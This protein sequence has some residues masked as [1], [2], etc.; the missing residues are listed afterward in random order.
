MKRC[1][2]CGIEKSLDEYHNIR[3]GNS[4][5]KK[6][7]C[8]CCVNAYNR[9]RDRANRV[10]ETIRKQKWREK[11]RKLNR[12]TQNEYMKRLWREDPVFKLVESA[13]VRL[14][15]TCKKKGVIRTK[16]ASDLFGCTGNE[17]REHIESLFKEGMCWDNHGEWHLDHIRPISSFE[18]PMDPECW[19]YKNIQPLWAAENLKK[20]NRVTT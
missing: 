3:R 7:I 9:K 6:A 13:R 11:N 14:R 20:G 8:K 12:K 15:E 5:K 1:K 2:K 16:S 10:S 18:N 4:S 19:S 17:L